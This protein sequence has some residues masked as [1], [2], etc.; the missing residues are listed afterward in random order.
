[1]T[2]VETEIDGRRLQVR[3]DRWA[4]DVAREMGAEIP[5]LCHHPALPPYG[6]CRLCVVQVKRR[7][8]TWL[9]TSCDL[10]IREGLSIRTN[11]PAVLAARKLTLEL[12]WAAAPDATVIAELAER[13]GVA[14]PRF[15]DRGGLGKCILCGLCIRA[16]R[17][18]LGQP[19][20][21]FSRRGEER[22][23]GTPF[24]AA[25]D[26]CIGCS[27]CLHICPTGHVTGVDERFL[28]R[29]TTWNTELEL[30]RC[31]ACGEAFGT[32]RELERLR[33]GARGRF[34]VDTI[35]PGCRRSRTAARLARQPGAAGRVT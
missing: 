4:I 32:V 34:P 25:S 26:T 30:A 21:C 6:A 16:C 35:C 13:F 12:L 15:A 1:M 23:V 17:S 22:R 31:A 29:M 8:W 28:R 20:I 27:A 19:A 14:K 3:R 5:S 18:V 2:W 33:A 11:T 9:A 10:P 24:A 7:Q